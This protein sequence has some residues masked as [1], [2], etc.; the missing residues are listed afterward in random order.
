MKVLSIT[1]HNPAEHRTPGPGANGLCSWAGV[2][3]PHE[4]RWTVKTEHKRERRTHAACTK[5]LHQIIDQAE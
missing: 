5:H 4:A 2:E 1:P 3:T